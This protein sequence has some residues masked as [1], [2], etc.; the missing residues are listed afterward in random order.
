MLCPV[1]T[2]SKRQSSCIPPSRGPCGRGHGSVRIVEALE[3]GGHLDLEV[4]QARHP[5]GRLVRPALEAS[6]AVGDLE[7]EHGARGHG[8]QR[9]DDPVAGLEA[10]GQVL[11]VHHEAKA[12]VQP[13]G[14]GEGEPEAKATRLGGTVGVGPGALE[15]DPV[16]REPDETTLPRVEVQ[17]GGDPRSAEEHRAFFE[18]DLTRLDRLGLA[19]LDDGLLGGALG[20]EEERRLGGALAMR[21]APELGDLG[22]EA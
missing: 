5:A 15:V 13:L 18:N 20:L 22:A 4:L 8:D 7:V 2:W 17:V 6:A 21:L 1:T 10:G 14:V 11:A 12:V 3:V 19:V 9:L 16:Q